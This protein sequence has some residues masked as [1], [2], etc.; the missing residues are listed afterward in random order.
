MKLDTMEVGQIWFFPIPDPF[1]RKRRLEFR[2][3]E[4]GDFPVPGKEKETF[5][6]AKCCTL[7]DGREAVI[8]AETMETAQQKD[9]FG[10]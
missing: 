8:S 10:F 7:E 9:R 3:I 4:I 1:G 2:I 6:G 5:R